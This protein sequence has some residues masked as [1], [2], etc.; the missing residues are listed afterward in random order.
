MCGILGL[1]NN[2][3]IGPIS[4]DLIK[5]LF[6]ISEK[7]GSD[8]FGVVIY[9]I[10]SKQVVFDFKSILPP[11]KVDLSD[12]IETFN[13]KRGYLLLANL[14]AQPETETK[15]SKDNL[16]PITK[17]NCTVVHNGSIDDEYYEKYIDTDS[18][19]TNIDSECIIDAYLQYFEIDKVNPLKQYMQHTIGGHAF[20]FYDAIEKVLTSVTDFKPLY[21][22]EGTNWFIFSSLPEINS[23]IEEKFAAERKGVYRRIEGFTI[24]LRNLDTS[25]DIHVQADTFTPLYKHPTFDLIAHDHL[26]KIHRDLYIVLA[27]GGIDSSLTAWTLGSLGHDVML[28]HFNYGQKGEKAERFGLQ[29]IYEIMLKKNMK[30]FFKEFDLTQLFYNDQSQLIQKEIK[31]TT[32]TKDIKSTI[33]WVSSRNLVFSTYAICLAEQSILMNQY[34]KVYITGGFFNLTESGIYPD[35][36]EYFGLALNEATKFGTLCPKDIEFVP[37]FANVMK[38]EEWVLGRMLNFPFRWTVSCDEPKLENDTIYLCDNCGSTKLSCWA[39]KMV[40]IRDPRNFYHIEGRNEND[41]KMKV[42]V[43]SKKITLFEVIEKLNLTQYDK[44]LLRSRC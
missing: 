8:G 14:R 2:S 22:A 20:L 37:I 3:L 9:D 25:N 28:L 36:S 33:A 13:K 12:I 41:Y 27:S 11:S 19:I 7:R 17:H 44:N 43:G 40:D 30:V 6:L 32:G 5:S 15:S 21:L 26:N 18:K 31:V 16:Q 38:S 42:E 35:N 24:E 23:L 10:D 29:K 4:P 39:A 1:Y 34:G